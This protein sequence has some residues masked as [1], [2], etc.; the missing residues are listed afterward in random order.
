MSQIRETD[1]SD[2]GG[3]MTFTQFCKKHKVTKEEREQ[4]LQHL[5]CLHILRA[6]RL[7]V[8]LYKLD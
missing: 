2:I 1:G 3:T 4:L 6:R 7:Y 5:M 8:H